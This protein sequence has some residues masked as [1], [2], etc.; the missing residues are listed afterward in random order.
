MDSRELNQ[1]NTFLEGQ[2][3]TD[4]A[5]W[6]VSRF[7][8]GL[9]ATTSMT[10][11][12]LIDV[13]TA[14]DPFLEVV[15]ID[16]GFHFDETLATLDRVRGRY[17]LNVTVKRA[18]PAGRT[19]DQCCDGIKVPL[20]DEALAG[21]QAWL[22]GVRRADGGSRREAQAVSIDRR[23]LVKVNPLVAWSDDDVADYIEA[24]DIIVNPLV[25]QGY[26]SIGCWPCTQLPVDASDPRSGRWAGTTRTECGLHV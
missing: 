5:R 9:V 11:A 24:H 14:A 20:L 6:A 16:T 3:A 21:K 13:A 26:T 23:G 4:I 15:F 12:V 7:G 8:S 19:P 2:S 17:D 22:S 18:D 25:A 1:V 10:D